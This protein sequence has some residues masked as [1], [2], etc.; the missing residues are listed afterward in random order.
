M[1]SR[2]SRALLTPFEALFSARWNEVEKLLARAQILCIQEAHGNLIDMQLLATRRCQT[3]H[4]MMS[5]GPQVDTGGI[6]I[7]VSKALAP[8][9]PEM[10]VYC[11]RTMRWRW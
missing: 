4:L 8:T 10:K 5:P 3:H 1:A 11:P 7:W 6:L 9:C 2:N